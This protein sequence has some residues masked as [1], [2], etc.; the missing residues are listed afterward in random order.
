MARDFS[1]STID[2]LWHLWSF[3]QKPVA[4]MALPWALFTEEVSS[5]QSATGDLIPKT[6][7]SSLSLLREIK[8]KK[9]HIVSEP[10]RFT[11]PD[12]PPCRRGAKAYA[13]SSLKSPRACPELF[14]HCT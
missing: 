8:L 13:F 3:Y 6:V 14:L 4:T 10:V 1:L 2:S 12:I 11:L 7:G 5:T 9:K